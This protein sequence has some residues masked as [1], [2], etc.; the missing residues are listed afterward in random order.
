MR[1]ARKDRRSYCEMFFCRKREVS[2]LYRLLLFVHLAAVMT[3]VG[4]MVFALFCL[5]PAAAV[6]PP[7]Q[8]IAL[9]QQALGRFF[10][11]VSLVILLIIAS[12]MSMIAMVAMMATGGP[13]AL[14]AAWWVMIGAGVLMMAIF[15]HV[16]MVPYKRLIMF[17]AAQD[18]PAAAA[19]LDR[20]RLMVMVNLLL[21]LVIIALM[22]MAV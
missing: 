13:K 19:Q 4:G 21:G 7:P 15:G 6:L 11:L 10:R 18:W 12:G 16:R 20:I 17:S 3:W 9:M 2:M 5:R 1:D 22:K 8:R 14:P